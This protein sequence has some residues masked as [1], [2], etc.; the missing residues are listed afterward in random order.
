M[1][2]KTKIKGLSRP[3]L[4]QLNYY[5]L[6]QGVAINDYFEDGE[7]LPGL[8]SEKI[9]EIRVIPCIFPNVENTFRQRKLINVASEVIYKFFPVV[10]YTE[11][12][13][14][15]YLTHTLA[16]F[17]TENFKF[18]NMQKSEQNYILSNNEYL[19]NL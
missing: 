14:L 7:W 1:K 18:V 4:W 8:N 13:G 12:K 10:L 5:W 2:N 15:Y 3:V 16:W 9:E 6:V 17:D 19:I 11:K